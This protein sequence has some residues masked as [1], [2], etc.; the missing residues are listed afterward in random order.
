MSCHEAS[1]R[2]AFSVPGGAK[3]FT[4]YPPSYDFVSQFSEM[5]IFGDYENGAIT[6]LDEMKQRF[7]GVIKHVRPED[8]LDCKDANEIL[9][10][11]GREQILK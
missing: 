2:N 11:Y 7:G 9:L 6:L 8:Y 4:W 3:G 10:K 1:I 5:I